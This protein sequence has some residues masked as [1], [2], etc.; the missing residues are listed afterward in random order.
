[1]GRE[2]LEAACRAVFDS[3]LCQRDL[4][5]AWHAGEPL[6][7]PVTFYE[8][9]L[10]IINRLNRAQVRVRH[11]IQTNGVLIDE[12]WCAFF[13]RHG[14]KVG[15]SLDGP[16]FLH[17]A[18]RLKRNGR[19]SHADAMRAVR[20]MQEARIPFEVIAVVTRNTLAHP[21]AFIEFFLSE[22]IPGIAL[23]IEEIEGNHAD[24]SLA[25]AEATDDFRRFLTVVY[26]MVRA[27]GSLR[28]RELAAIERYLLGGG[29]VVPTMYRPLSN[30]TVDC[31]GNFTVFAP[32]LLGAKHPVH[33]PLVFGNVL[34]QDFDSVLKTE[35]FRTVYAEVLKGL[36]MCKLSC[37]YHSVCGGNSPSNKLFENHTFASTETMD[38]RLNRKIAAE[39]VL[40]ELEQA[41]GL[42]G[43]S[44]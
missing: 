8:G 21:E 27:S 22:K 19:G 32:E 24:S 42:P 11:N 34:T 17:D 44:H 18:S 40:E 20:L 36:R 35:R 33:G 29:L 28:V 37:Q 3:R 1:M 6:V 41:Y 9:A 23:N 7:L 14:I 43:T 26:K 30:V 13:L 38:C 2:V 5:I 25:Y 10:A 16:A 4:T 15:L 12:K 31:D 39:V